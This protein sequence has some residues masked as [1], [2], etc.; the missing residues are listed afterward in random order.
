MPLE[1]DWFTQLMKTHLQAFHTHA[2]SAAEI[3]LSDE[4]KNE[5][6][7]IWKVQYKVMKRDVE[8]YLHPAYLKCAYEN[9]NIIIPYTVKVKVI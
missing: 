6:K 7:E 2:I 1:V 4:I 9:G 8:E 3:I 5:L